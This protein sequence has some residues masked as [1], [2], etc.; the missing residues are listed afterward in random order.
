MGSGYRLQAELLPPRA[1]DGASGTANRTEDV[2][3]VVDFG[4]VGDG[5]KYCA[6]AVNKA[7]RAAKKNGGGV[8]YFPPGRY[9]FGQQGNTESELQITSSNITLRGAGN[10][11]S[12]ETSSILYLDH[13]IP[14][15]KFLLYGHGH[16]HPGPVEEAAGVHVVASVPAEAIKLHVSDVSDYSA[17]DCFRLHGNSKAWL[18]PWFGDI[19]LDPKW[20]DL[21]KQGIT[22]DQPHCVAHVNHEASVLTLNSPIHTEI[23]IKKDQTSLK[24]LRIQMLSDI[25]IEMLRFESGWKKEKKPLCHLCDDK[26]TLGWQAILLTL[27]KDSYIR[28]CVFD[29]WIGSVKLEMS[30]ANTVSHNAVVGK[31]GHHCYRT[32]RSY[33]NLF[34]ENSDTAGTWHGPSFEMFDSGSVF[35]R[36]KLARGQAVD[37]HGNLPTH[38]LVDGA[39]GGVLY[40]AGGNEMAFPNHAEK[41]TIWNF[42]HRAVDVRGKKYLLS[43]ER[44]FYFFDIPYLVVYEFTSGVI[45]S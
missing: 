20:E 45:N 24:L 28:D 39:S 11:A 3:N 17:G 42:E 19:P 5:I 4:A 37:A 25:G 26:N 16:H 2:F 13:Y 9:R 18:T 14:G 23:V 7:I 35:L 43:C 31:P 41:L 22:F 12:A 27:V 36:H 44:L 40:G 21:S 15:N 8:V 1:V 30:R 10:S 33:G 32:L 38:T 34:L 29:S 6:K